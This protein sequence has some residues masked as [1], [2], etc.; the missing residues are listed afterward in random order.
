M[1][2]LEKLYKHFDEVVMQIE[3]AT[4][5]RNA[6]IHSYNMAQISTMVAMKRGL[7]V[8]FAVFAGLLHDIALFQY[9][10]PE[11]HAV[12]GAII[13]RK[14]LQEWSLTAQEETDIV[15]TAIHFHGSK[16]TIEGE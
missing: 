7:D 4:T 1:N 2:R 12:K 11:A 16:A 3:D 6:L 5:R 13:A 14:L 10:S 15:C 8:E 9:V